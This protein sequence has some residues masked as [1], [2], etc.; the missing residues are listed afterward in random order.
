MTGQSY[1]SQSKE[2]TRRPQ[3]GPQQDRFFSYSSLTAP[4][5][6]EEARSKQRY[7]SLTL[8][9]GLNSTGMMSLENQFQGMS[10]Q[11]KFNQSTRLQAQ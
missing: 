5:N 10:V 2:G 11:N 3:K 9:S 4:K 8:F 1:A 6:D 7:R